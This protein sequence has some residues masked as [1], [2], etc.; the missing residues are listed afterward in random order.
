ML[1]SDQYKDMKQELMGIF[2]TQ[3]LVQHHD[4][5][6]GTAVNRVSQDYINKLDKATQALHNINK[7]ILK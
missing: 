6:T 2:E 3:G 7:R 5:I 4:A 1:D